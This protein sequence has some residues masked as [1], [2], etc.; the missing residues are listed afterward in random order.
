VRSKFIGF[1]LDE[2]LYEQLVEYC[3][4]EHSNTSQTVR[5]IV[6]NYLRMQRD[7]QN[8]IPTTAKIEEV[9]ENVDAMYHRLQIELN[10]LRRKV[11][12]QE[13]ALREKDTRR[14][15]KKE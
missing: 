14:P 12:A 15:K 8:G 5:K 2:D 10:E 6:D 11:A 7:V 1:R 4:K 9:A 3:E 13:K